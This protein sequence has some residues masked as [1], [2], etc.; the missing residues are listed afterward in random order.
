VL[1][2]RDKEEDAAEAKIRQR[3]DIDQTDK[4]Q[5]VKAR[6]GQGIFK[7]TLQMIEKRCRITGL[8]DSV[9]LRASHIKPWCKCDD[10]ERLD[11]NNGLLLSPHIDHLFDRGFISFKDSGDLLVA[12]LLK[13]QVLKTWGISPKLNAGRFRPEQIKYLEYHRREVFLGSCE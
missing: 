2:E 9:H 10:F 6:R 8:K 5:L 12:D 3:T 1:E 11:G 4:E 7:S 13:E